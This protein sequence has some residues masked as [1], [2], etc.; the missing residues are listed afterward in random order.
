MCYIVTHPGE[1]ERPLCHL[2]T[3]LLI[4]QIS[5]SSCEIYAQMS[6]ARLTPL[7]STLIKMHDESLLVLQDVGK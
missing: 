2:R 1:K 7:F 4:S 5:R 3:E 6:P